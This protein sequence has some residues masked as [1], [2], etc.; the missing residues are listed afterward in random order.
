MSIQTESIRARCAREGITFHTGKDQMGRDV[1]LV[2]RWAMSR[3]FD[4][5]AEVSAW[6][7]QVTGKAGTANDH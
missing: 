1:Y 7:D 3:T 5:L 6:L 4:S 2:S